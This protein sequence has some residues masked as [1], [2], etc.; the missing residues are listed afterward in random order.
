MGYGRWNEL[1]Q[2]IPVFPVLKVLGA[3]RVLSA[4]AKTPQDAHISQ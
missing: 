3:P 1:Q 4:S 2:T